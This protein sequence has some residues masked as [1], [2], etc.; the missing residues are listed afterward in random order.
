VEASE[1]ITVQLYT[2]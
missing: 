2:K 1:S